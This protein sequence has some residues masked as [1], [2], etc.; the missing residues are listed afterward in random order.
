MV[1]AIQS[2]RSQYW[3]YPGEAEIYGINFSGR[4]RG[5]AISGTSWGWYVQS[6]LSAIA[7]GVSGYSGQSAHYINVTLSGGS[8]NSG[9]WVSGWAVTTPSARLLMTALN[10]HITGATGQG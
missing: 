9:Y 3:K 7:S 1:S 4:L 6:G 8:Y 5:E 10:V 2:G